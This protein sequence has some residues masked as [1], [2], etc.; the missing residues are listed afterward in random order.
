MN[1]GNDNGNYN[2]VYNKGDRNGNG[3]GNGKGLNMFKLL[4]YKICVAQDSNVK[5]IPI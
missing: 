1:D 5:I 2:G 4:T 3:N